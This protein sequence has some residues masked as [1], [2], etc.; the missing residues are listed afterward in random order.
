LSGRELLEAHRFRLILL[1]TADAALECFGKMHLP[2]SI[3][4]VV[5]ELVESNGFALLSLSL[6]R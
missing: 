1:Q 2:A 5:G 6:W 3:A 4:L